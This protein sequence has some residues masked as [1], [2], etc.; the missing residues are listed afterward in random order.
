MPFVVVI[1]AVAIVN[2]GDD[3]AWCFVSVL[4]LVVFVLFNPNRLCWQQQK[5]H[6]SHTEAVTV[7]LSFWI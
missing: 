1:T 4:S 2:N 6:I 5:R 3:N 7:H